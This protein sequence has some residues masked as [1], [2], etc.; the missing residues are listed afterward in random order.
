MS[1]LFGYFLSQYQFFFLSL[2][3]FSFRSLI[4]EEKD[5]RKNSK[6]EKG[7]AVHPISNTKKFPLRKLIPGQAKSVPYQ[8]AQ[9]EMYIQSIHS[10]FPISLSSFPSQVRKFTKK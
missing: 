5:V 1:G 4:G 2:S 9:N 6:K 10:F 7:L 8:Y 3:L